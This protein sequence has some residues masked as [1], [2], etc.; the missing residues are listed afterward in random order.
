MKTLT[1][2]QLRFVSEYLVDM[3]ATQAAI[4]AG[5]STRDADKIGSDLLGKTRVAAA[6]DEAIT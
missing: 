3:N 5:Y 2:K 4:R 1:A 6:V